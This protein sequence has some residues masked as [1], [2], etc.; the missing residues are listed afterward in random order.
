MKR[1]VVDIETNMK[2]SRI[3]LAVTKNIDTKETVVWKEARK[4]SAYIEDATL[5]IGHNIIGFDSPTLDRLWKTKTSD[6]PMTDTL[7]LSR[8]L[9][10]SREGGHSLE[11]WGKT[12]GRLKIDYAQ[13]WEKALEREEE[14]PGECFDY[15]LFDLLDEYCRGD[16]DVTEALYR[17]LTKELEAKKFSQKSIDLEHQTAIIIAQQERNG[18]KLDLPYATMLL[19]DLKGK[20]EQAN[21]RMQQR[22]P[23]YTVERYSEKTGK[24]LKDSVVAFNPG[25]RQQIGEKLKELGWKP[26]KFTEK[27]QPQID[28][29][30]LEDIIN[31]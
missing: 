8:L 25:S 31:H 6:T 29:S 28:E 5:L 7:I 1:L 18:F 19:A 14:Y 15:P 21:E 13:A 3:W 27:G 23:P 11:A 20:L 26:T 30:V 24:R 12:L 17:H 2:H 9:D 22:W 16:V 10:P 4:F